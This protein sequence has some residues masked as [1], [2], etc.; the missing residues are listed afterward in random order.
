MLISKIW[1]RTSSWSFTSSQSSQTWGSS[2]S[3]SSS[4]GCTGLKNTSKRSVGSSFTRLLFCFSSTL[5]ADPENPAPTHGRQFASESQST[6][7]EKDVEAQLQHSL[8]RRSP[9]TTSASVTDAPK[10]EAPVSRQQTGRPLAA[11][12]NGDSNACGH[13]ENPNP[14][15]VAFAEGTLPPRNTK[16]LRVPSPRERDTGM[17]LCRGDSVLESLLT[18]QKGH[19]LEEVNQAMSDEGKPQPA[20]SLSP[21][22][23]CLPQHR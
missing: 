23:S 13:S 21:V 16:A 2:I 20:F 17:E 8:G 5:A 1:R 15:Q 14:T 19:P 10:D 12:S 9:R 22:P 6:A 4:S 7:V 3:S 18:R 11:E